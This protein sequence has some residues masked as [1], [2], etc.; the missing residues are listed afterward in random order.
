MRIR[1]TLYPLA[2]GLFVSLALMVGLFLSSCTTNQ[3][4]N[5]VGNVEQKSTAL[6]TPVTDSITAIPLPTPPPSTTSSP[7]TSHTEQLR[8]FEV[9]RTS[10][11]LPTVRPTVESASE[12]TVVQSVDEGSAATPNA[13]LA[14]DEA[15]LKSEVPAATETSASSD[16]RVSD[17]D[18]ASGIQPCAADSPADCSQRDVSSISLFT[19]GVP[20]G[21]SAGPPPAEP[22]VEDY[23]ERGYWG[24]IGAPAH[25]SARGFLPA[26]SVRCAWVGTAFTLPRRAAFIR[27]YMGI[28]E[29][30]R[31]PS[32]EEILQE[33]EQQLEGIPERNRPHLM[34]PLENVVK[35]GLSESNRTMNCYAD[36]EVHE[37]LLG[38]G[39][40]LVT[41]A[42]R[43]FAPAH[44]WDFYDNVIQG[45]KS[46]EFRLTQD[47]YEDLIQERL[48]TFQNSMADT[49][50]GR[51]V[52]VFLSP[53]SDWQNVAV[54]G[55]QVVAQWDL[56]M[57]AEYDSQVVAAR[58]STR[59]EDP[60]YRRPLDTLRELIAEAAAISTVD[61]MDD[62]RDLNAH[63]RAI[64]AYEDLTP[65]DGIDNPFTPNR[66]PAVSP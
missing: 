34:A 35:G 25:I 18:G 29:E 8:P 33:F 22:S 12:P 58:Y 28:G 66:P 15:A 1:G 52:V 5:T 65:G 46:E 47:K 61:R 32:D 27:S 57:S 45:G 55:W 53:L 11:P 41:V 63:Y 10:T 38:D 37:Y 42:Y 23:L 9:A 64:G 44:S 56:Q 54:E 43:T 36:I 40:E 30:E 60:E 20:H 16:D 6:A 51:E 62:I 17:T 21:D 19:I 49:I 26:A 13:E 2:T 3:A 7:A 59:E 48:Q 14:N 31:L 50:G 24:E 39:P 4:Q